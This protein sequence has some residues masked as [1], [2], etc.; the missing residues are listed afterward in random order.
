MSMYQLVSHVFP[1]S[2]DSAWSHRHASGPS[3]VHRYRHTTGVPLCASGPRNS[4]TAPVNRPVT[5][6]SMAPP[7]RL[8]SQYSDHQS[9]SGSRSRSVIAW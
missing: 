2:G 7:P 6:E 3:T 4:P 5:G 8:V 9:D 1:S